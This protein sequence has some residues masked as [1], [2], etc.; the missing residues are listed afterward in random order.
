MESACSPSF[1]FPV[2][3]SGFTATISPITVL[4]TVILLLFP[5][6]SKAGEQQA[7][8]DSTQVQRKTIYKAAAY[9]S[10]FF[11]GSMVI[12]GKPGIKTEIV[13][14]FIFTTITKAICRWISLDM[15][16]AR[17]STAMSGIT[18]YEKRGSAE[19]KLYGLAQ[20][21][22]LSFKPLLKL[23]TAC[24]KGTVSHGAIWLQMLSGRCW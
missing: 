22:G 16:L 19:K 23:W 3:P 13:F 21:S 5:V 2:N 6:F 15:P 1:C 17:T 8:A 4:F 20:H 11:T 10:A 14:R 18:T 24:T 7:K 9:T 12:L